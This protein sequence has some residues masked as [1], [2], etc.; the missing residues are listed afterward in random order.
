V[1][2]IIC[3]G[4]SVHDLRRLDISSIAAF[5]IL[6]SSRRDIVGRVLRWVRRQV[7]WWSAARVCRK[8][9]RI[10]LVRPPTWAEWLIA[11]HLA[12]RPR[13]RMIHEDAGRWQE[14]WERFGTDL[15]RLTGESL[16]VRSAV[17]LNASE[18]D[19]S[20]SSLRDRLKRLRSKARASQRSVEDESWPASASLVVLALRTR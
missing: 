6:G 19:P 13:R 11:R 16:S 12:V 8:A 10:V 2:H 14:R 5:P 20:T 17:V 9:D 18:D 4:I 3:A 1:I 7:G 15:L